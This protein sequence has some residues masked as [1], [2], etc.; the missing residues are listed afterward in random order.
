MSRLDKTITLTTRKEKKRL[1]LSAL[2]KEK[3]ED[4][5]H[6]MLFGLTTTLS[7]VGR[8]HH[9]TWPAQATDGESTIPDVH[10]MVQHTYKSRSALYHERE[11]V[12]RSSMLTFE[13]E[14]MKG[15][16]IPVQRP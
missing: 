4:E 3:P 9:K 6:C 1:C 11:G 7:P 14:C 2:L 16:G 12:S 8:K 10:S 5:I 15:M 13:R